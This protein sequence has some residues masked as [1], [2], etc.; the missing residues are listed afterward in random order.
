[1]RIRANTTIAC[2]GWS[3]FPGQVVDVPREEAQPIVAAGY[4]EVV[5][6]STVRTAEAPAPQRQA[7]APEPEAPEEK[8]K[9]RKGRVRR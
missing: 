2:A 5:P 7:I 6:T 3:A 9:H 4:A 8:T 1:M